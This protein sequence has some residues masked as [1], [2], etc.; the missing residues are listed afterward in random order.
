MF[1]VE[2][3]AL[4]RTYA[5]ERLLIEPWGED[6]LRVRGT[7]YAELDREHWALDEERPHDIA[8]IRI[9]AGGTNASVR[10]GEILARVD[11]RGQ[12]SY[13]NG[14]GKLLLAE[15]MR[16]RPAICRPEQAKSTSRRSL[17]SIAR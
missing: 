14:S 8:D 5:G 3:G 16:M 15:Y 4:L 12:I 17:I 11:P 10:N 6:A 1:S 13:Y 9:D 7:M 2:N